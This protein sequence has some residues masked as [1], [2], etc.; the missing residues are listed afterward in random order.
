MVSF[1]LMPGMF[2]FSL[3]KVR[4]L[5]ICGKANFANPE[6]I[7]GEFRLRGVVM[8]YELMGV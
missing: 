2:L 4:P 3:A 8:G 7:F 1:K 6:I 5:L